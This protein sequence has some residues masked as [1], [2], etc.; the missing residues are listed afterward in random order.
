MRC[1]AIVA[2]LAC[3]NFQI[4]GWKIPDGTSDGVYAV[5]P[6][7]DGTEVHSRVGEIPSVPNHRQR[8]RRQML[9]PRNIAATVEEASSKLVPDTAWTLDCW[10]DEEKQDL[11]HTDCDAANDALDAQCRDGAPLANGRSFYSI[12]G[13]VVDYF[14]NFHSWFTIDDAICTKDDRKQT[15]GLIT[16]HCGWNF[17]GMCPI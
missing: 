8:A 16:G 1:A 4:H 9:T 12:S 6:L 15:S 11:N 5:D 10:R 17:C 13:C 2:I 7:P 3:F 14:C